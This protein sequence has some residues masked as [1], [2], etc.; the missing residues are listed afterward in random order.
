MKYRIL[1]VL[2]LV[3]NHVSG[4]IFKNLGFKPGINFTQFA[5]ELRES[6]G[7]PAYNFETKRSIGYNLFITTDLIAKKRWE[8]NS[9]LGFVQKN[10]THTFLDWV[11]TTSYRSTTKYTLN[12]ISLINVI[13]AKIP[14]SNAFNVTGS[15]GPRLEYLLDSPQHLKDYVPGG[16]FYYNTREDIH[17]LALGLSASV[18]VL[19]K[20]KKLTWEI[21][22]GRNFNFNTIIS[23]KG[24]RLDGL[25]D[26]GFYLKMKD[27]TYMINLL[28]IFDL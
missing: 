17:R 13:K 9:S 4:Q 26:A 18:G 19:L 8:V 11:Q 25:G 2:A 22:A 6:S 28:C 21:D 12:Y 16:F 15:A 7:F 20:L 24:P 23:A 1:L 5:W 10:G 27:E 14:I 3:T